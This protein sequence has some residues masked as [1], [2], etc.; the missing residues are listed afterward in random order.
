MSS[1]SSGL[2]SFVIDGSVAVLLPV[3]ASSRPE[4]GPAVV[5]EPV[6]GDR[7]TVVEETLVFI[8]SRP[9]ICTIF[10]FVAVA[11]ASASAS[12]LALALVLKFVVLVFAVNAFAMKLVLLVVLRA[13]SLLAG[14]D[15]SSRRLIVS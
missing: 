8:A 1:M 3:S 4:E 6:V 13:I 2:S 5:E 14:L 15:L 11:R 12:A 7:Q 9:L 10:K